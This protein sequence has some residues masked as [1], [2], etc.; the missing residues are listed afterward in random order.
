MMGDIQQNLANWLTLAS[1]T[2]LGLV[3]VYY[4]RH[5]RQLERRQARQINREFDRELAEAEA[6][7]EKWRTFLYLWDEAVASGGW[8][9]SL[10]MYRNSAAGRDRPDVSPIRR[11]LTFH[12]A[13]GEKDVT[14]GLLR[15]HAAME[16]L[17]RMNGA[18]EE[19]RATAESMLRAAK[20]PLDRTSDAVRELRAKLRDQ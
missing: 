13:S 5:S 15:V 10:G 4:A 2:L 17:Q 18:S 14:E 6:E 7:I 1:T 3:T 11:T 20:G 16:F 19:H 9:E 12:L 8:Q